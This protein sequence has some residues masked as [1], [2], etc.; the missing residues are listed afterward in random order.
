[1]LVRFSL[2]AAVFLLSGC[3]STM[4]KMSGAFNVVKTYSS[5][6][7]EGHKDWSII[8]IEHSGSGSSKIFAYKS[9]ENALKKAAASHVHN[10]KSDALLFPGENNYVALRYFNGSLVGEKIFNNIDG[11]KGKTY[12]LKVTG[13]GA[14]YTAEL[15]D[16]ETGEKVDYTLTRTP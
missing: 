14:N 1:M 9:S 15:V 2:V 11:V 5:Q 8:K 13:N 7:R 4:D 16:A 12:L 10:F 3:I 6:D